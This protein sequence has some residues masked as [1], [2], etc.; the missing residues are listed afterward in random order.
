[1]WQCVVVGVLARMKKFIFRTVRRLPYIGKKID[2]EVEKQRHE[3]EEKF[4]E[5]AKGQSYL[6]QLPAKGMSEVKLPQILF[7]YLAI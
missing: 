6:Q 2:A 5:T 3:M 7:C 4:H 1:M